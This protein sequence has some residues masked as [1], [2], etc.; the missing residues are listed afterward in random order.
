VV[1]QTKQTQLGGCANGSINKAV[2]DDNYSLINLKSFEPT[3]KKHNRAKKVFTTTKELRL[4]KFSLYRAFHS[5]YHRNGR[6]YDSYQ[7]LAD[8]ACS[9]HTPK[10]SNRDA[11][12]TNKAKEVFCF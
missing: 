11:L 9:Y 12:L 6:F 1:C 5:L 10:P 7:L 8:F 2:V 4:K 3:K